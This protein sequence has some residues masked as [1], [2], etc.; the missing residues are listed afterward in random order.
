MKTV[1]I[2]LDG[3][4]AYYKGWNGE[5]TP[6][7]RP[8]EGAL[9][10]SNKLIEAGHKIIIHTTRVTP[11]NN[12]PKGDW[13]YT[14]GMGS[15]NDQQFEWSGYL[16]KQIRNWLNENEFNEDIEIWTNIGKPLADIYIDDKAFNVFKNRGFNHQT[17]QSIL[18]YLDE[19]SNI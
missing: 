15:I 4:L 19:S 11:I 2:D 16:E 17:R 6:I 1:A 9:E 7:G 10:L 13:S 8:L 12:P 14:P 3:T 5:H 18:G